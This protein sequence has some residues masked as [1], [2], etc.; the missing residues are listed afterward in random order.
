MQDRADDILSDCEASLQ[1]STDPA[2]TDLVG[3]AVR[4]ITSH[5]EGHTEGAQALATNVL[6]TALSQH[7]D[8]GV[9]GLLR[10]CKRLKNGDTDKGTLLELRLRLATAGIPRSYQA[11]DYS[12]Q[13]GR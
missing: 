6:D 11:Y 5:R 13:D 7:H 3:L 8:D 1:Q 9:K 10:E 4:A 2:L 12:K